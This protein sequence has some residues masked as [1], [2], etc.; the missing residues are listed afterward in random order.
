LPS[1][2]NGETATLL[3]TAAPL[4]HPL[5][6][7]LS[8][9][10]TADTPDEASE[11]TYRDII[12]RISPLWLGVG[13]SGT[14]LVILLVNETVQGRWA[15]MMTGGEFDALA[16]VSSGVLR[17]MRIA[18]V[19]CLVIGYLPAAFLYVLRDGRRTILVLQQALNCTRE[20][21][22]TLAASV[23]LSPRWLLVI[24]LF[25]LLLSLTTPYLVPPAPEAPWNPSNWSP[26]VAWH[27]ILGPATM[28][29]GW[30]LG[31]AIVTVSLRMSRIAK[32]LSQL[33]LFDL[34]PLAPFTQQGLTNALLLI[35]LLSIWS[36][37]LIETGFGQIMWTVSGVILVTT[38]LALLAP[39]QGVHKRI[40]Q[41]KQEEIDWLDDEISKLRSSLQPSDSSPQSGRLAD[42]VAYRGL[43]ESVAEWP[44]TSSTYV[45]LAL[46]TLLPIS[47]WGVGLLA[48]E[49]VSQM[50]L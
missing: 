11:M 7:K 12:N 36:L 13:I 31:Y 46:Y 41:S 17:D 49:L 50:F 1:I 6:Q 48:E 30:W 24:G 3:K 16:I 39:V 40:R 15:E 20:E 2:P 8:D 44:F 9:Y 22:E 4:E 37:I 28:V 33:N 14:L 5:E 26:E 25:A 18:V 32:R 34:S 27:R 21:C 45:R 10:L 19:H 42:L 23:R 47:T 43:V 38:I 29:W 35:G